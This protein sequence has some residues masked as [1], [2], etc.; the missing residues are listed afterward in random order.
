MEFDKTTDDD[1]ITYPVSKTIFN[2]I[3]EKSAVNNEDVNNS[4][5]DD[6]EFKSFSINKLLQFADDLLIPLWYFLIKKP[7]ETCFDNITKFRLE[8]INI[9]LSHI[10][11]R[12]YVD[13]FRLNDVKNLCT[14]RQNWYLQYA[15]AKNLESKAFGKRAT[16]EDDWSDV[17]DEIIDTLNLETKNT[18]F[19]KCID[20]FNHLKEKIENA[21]ILL[22]FD[23]VVDFNE[24]KVLT[25]DKDF[26]GLSI[27][28]ADNR[29]PLIF[30]NSQACLKSQ[31]F[32]L[33]HE[34]AHIWLEYEY[35]TK[36][37]IAKIDEIEI[38]ERIEDWCNKVAARIIL[39]DSC[40]D[41]IL[42]KKS[43]IKIKMLYFNQLNDLVDEIA[44]EYKI[45]R[46]IV[47]KRF[48]ERNYI[49]TQEMADKLYSSSKE[50]YK[51]SIHLDEPVGT[52]NHLINNNSKQFL[53]A[54]IEQ[55]DDMPADSFE[56]LTGFSAK[57]EK[58]IELI[59]P[60]LSKR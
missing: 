36:D 39:P 31:T 58:M 57:N 22:M 15:T 41:T 28:G 17:A 35:V 53:S 42:E 60:L 44:N 11:K 24:K 14:R 6:Q 13:N 8:Y 5:N 25:I 45:C 54:V 16:I 56:Y 34:L 32:T 2:W 21:G 59:T 46:G 50:L 33:A 47:V 18:T 49:I 29:S 51:R 38:N 20:L 19:E 7:F 55:K 52:P 4:F 26:L 37:Y 3:I 30:I 23:Y 27:K 12:T 40:I 48:L 9:P 43:D 10:P 1:E